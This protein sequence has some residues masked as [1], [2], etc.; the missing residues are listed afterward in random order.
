MTTDP[1]DAEIARLNREIELLRVHRDIVW[2]TPV[3]YWQ[4]RAEKAEARITELE[5]A[6]TPLLAAAMPQTDDR[7]PLDNDMP[8]GYLESNRDWA[9]RND[10][11][12]TWLADNHVAIRTAYEA[13][14]KG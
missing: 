14:R 8:G 13:R 4:N 9:D 2:E 6:L 7:R 3:G 12:V 11:A 1:K 10:A 5:A